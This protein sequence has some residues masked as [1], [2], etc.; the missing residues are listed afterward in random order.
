MLR[1][2]GIVV[3]DISFRRL[4]RIICAKFSL[5]PPKYGVGLDATGRFRAFVDV[6][7]PRVGPMLEMLTY[8]GTPS[9]NIGQTQEDAARTP[10]ER[11]RDELHFEIKDSNYEERQFYENLY[12]QIASE[13]DTL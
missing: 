5:P 3:I 11:L 6:T 12:D 4:L 13:Y 1:L 10:V 2:I 9:T 8:W 7:V